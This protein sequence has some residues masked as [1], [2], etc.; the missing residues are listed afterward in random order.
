MASTV[1]PSFK[2]VGLGRRAASAAL[3]LAVILLAAVATRSAQAQTFTLLYQFSGGKDGGNPL[4]GLVEDAA[5]NLYGTTS[6]GGVIG[7]TCKILLGCGVVFK[8]D[9]SSKETVLYSFTGLADGESPSGGLILDPATG[10]LYGIAGGG[11]SK[12][13]VV[14]QVDT[15]GSNYAVLYSFTGGADGYGPQGSLVL[16]TATGN[17]YGATQG[18][19]A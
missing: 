8:L 2:I 4:A 1:Q 19:G 16:D 9:T 11:V 6:G 17:L 18:G 5:G 15:S 14:F 13:G 3:A 10:N 7:G 12:A